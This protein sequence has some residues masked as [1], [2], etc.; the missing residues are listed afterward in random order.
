MGHNYP[1]AINGLRSSPSLDFI[2]IQLLPPRIEDGNARSQCPVPGLRAAVPPAFVHCS[3][4]IGTP[5]LTQAG[6][7]AVRLSAR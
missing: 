7:S 3:R 5:P 2:F 6:P 1:A 4:S